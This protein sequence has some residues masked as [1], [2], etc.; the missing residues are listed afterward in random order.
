MHSK[1]LKKLSRTT[2]PKPT[3]TP[4]LPTDQ[5]DNNLLFYSLVAL[6][7]VTLTTLAYFGYRQYKKKCETT[8]DRDC[9]EDLV[10]DMT[11]E[12]SYI[13]GEVNENKLEIEELPVNDDEL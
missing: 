10:I 9:V 11:S 6:S 3:T 8:Q 1:A 13:P 7:S 2:K 4:T 5:K 12:V